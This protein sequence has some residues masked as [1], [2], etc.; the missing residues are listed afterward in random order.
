MSTFII[1]GLARMFVGR[2]GAYVNS[3]WKQEITK[4]LAVVEPIIFFRNKYLTRVNWVTI[5]FSFDF[6]KI[7]NVVN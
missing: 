6:L 7:I 3:V 2:V 5:M 4:R 1:Q